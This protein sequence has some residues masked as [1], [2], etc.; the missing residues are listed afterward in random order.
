M[1]ILDARLQLPL[2][3]GWLIDLSDHL[4]P[5]LFWDPLQFFLSISA[6]TQGFCYSHLLH[7]EYVDR[8][9]CY[10]ET[11]V[12]Q[13][14]CL[15][16]SPESQLR[17]FYLDVGA[18]PCRNDLVECLLLWVTLSLFPS[19]FTK[20]MSYYSEFENAFAIPLPL[21]EGR[22]FFILVWIHYWS[23]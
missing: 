4:H 5:D 10:A 9:L 7:T 6:S 17:G 14:I 3:I 2:F 15:F 19:W 20:P 11:L 13:W 22:G 18:H 16:W 8:H 12:Q 1:T 23:C 21:P